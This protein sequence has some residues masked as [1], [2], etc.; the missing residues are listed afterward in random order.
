MALTGVMLADFNSF[1]DACAKAEVSL[2]SFETAGGKVESGLT[3][4]A[5]SL[6]GVKLIQDASLMV[7]A[8]K[9]VGGAT[10]L[11]GVEQAKV[12]AVLDLALQKY[13]VLGIDAP[14]AM[15]KL[16]TETAKIPPAAGSVL[17][18]VAPLAGAFGVAFSAAAVVGF[19][20]EL[21]ADA[22]AMVKLAD[23]TGIAIEPLQRLKF[24]AEQSGNTFEQVS[25]AVT[26]MQQRIAGGNK[27]AVGAM[28][29]L[30]IA[31]SEFK[32]LS[33][34]DQFIRIA[35]EV[36]KI[37]DPMERARVALELFGRSGAE[38]LPTLIANVKELGDQSPVM[39]ERAVKAFDAV[40][41]AASRSW[42]VI[43]NA[44][45][46]GLGAA[47]DGYGRLLD[48]AAALA[49][50]DLVEAAAVLAD[51]KTELIEVGPP[52]DAFG[53]ATDQL[54][55]SWEEAEAAGRQLTR[56]VETQ[57]SN[58]RHMT[59][60][61]ADLKKATEARTTA[62]DKAADAAAKAG[63]KAKAAV[64]NLIQPTRDVAA[65]ARNMGESYVDAF[66]AA[67]RA[68]ADL[69]EE[70]KRLREEERKR[71]LESRSQGGSFNITRENFAATA[72]GLGQD[73]GLVERLLHQG[74][75]FEQAMLWARHPEWP[76]PEHPGPR[77]PGFAMGVE[78]F[79]G[80]LAMVGERGPE[81]VNL[82]SGSNVTPF[83]LGSGGATHYH[84]HIH[85]GTIVGTEQAL[86]RLVQKAMV[87]LARAK[88]KRLGN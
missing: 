73:A 44:T 75:S 86:A 51:L 69:L 88:G 24:I 54:G 74:Y 48:I 61:E 50:G 20:R 55:L 25:G 84:A 28:Q 10:T 43:K 22:D 7:E 57:I 60:L 66:E 85:A 78:N 38:V 30:G 19:G 72:R 52:T 1:T 14:A 13:R 67:S 59:D 37:E 79:A 82:P 87:D 15:Q 9:R 12:N 63:D 58:A 80:G 27:D 49:H 46:E 36:A 53:T 6:S 4:M 40:G 77:V 21:L 17:S 64:E 18:S 76:P 62:N 3:R 39:S 35:T 16:H 31:M 81:L 23:K 32:S 26:S 34:D 5:N 56:E 42:T 65:E 45:G 29:Q 8:V 11:T 70:Q 68:A 33:P 41:D 2:K 47:I 71:Q 83:G